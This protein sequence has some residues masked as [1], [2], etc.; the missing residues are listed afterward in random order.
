MHRNAL[1]LWVGVL[2][3]SQSMRPC[4]EGDP[5]L[6]HSIPLAGSFATLTITTGMRGELGLSRL[7]HILTHLEYVSGS[8]FFSW[9]RRASTRFFFAPLFDSLR[10]SVSVSLATMSAIRSRRGADAFSCAL[11]ISLAPS[12]SGTHCC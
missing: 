11:A 12:L 1:E 5:E 8:E 2:V 6:S 3:Q 10:L 9:G 7:M 4:V